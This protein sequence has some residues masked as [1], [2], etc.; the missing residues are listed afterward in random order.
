[1]P[2]SSSRSPFPAT[3]MRRM[4]RSD[5]SRRIM[6]ESRLSPDD[7]IYPVFVL[8]GQ[9]QREAVPSM[10][11]VERMSVELLIEEA[12]TIYGLGVPAMALF[13]VTPMQVKTEDA[14]EAFNPDGLAQRAVRA[15]KD[16]VPDLGI[17]TDVALDPFT[18]HGQD[19][20]IDATGY[21]LN[22]E[23][24][25]VLVKQALSHAAAGAD[26]V[27]PSDM[28]DGRIGDIRTALES[29]GHIHTRI[30]AYSA[31]YAS[32]F[33]GPFRDAV[34]SAANLGGGN[35]YS[36]QQDP[37]NSDEAL[38]EVALDLQEGADMV[39]VKP[40]MPYLDI[41]RRIKDEFMVPTFAYQVSGEYAMLK[42]AAQNGWL[43]EQ[44]VV[45]ESL[46]CIK[47]AGADGILTYFARQ[48]AE[49]LNA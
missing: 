29:D 37:A 4:R 7:F 26:V 49:W 13:P 43:D 21:V 10:P 27:A 24:K 3:R 16:A 19:G 47:R 42:A 25:E 6:R 28:M 1:M 23:T 8:E 38:H 11:G 17:I 9:G 32:S 48:A 2:N 31:K 15:L 35:K 5:F 45:M 14:R 40:G 20:L 12:K 22:D 44:A 46:L 39:M 33:Y 41:V 36:Y 34:G 18:T 30:L